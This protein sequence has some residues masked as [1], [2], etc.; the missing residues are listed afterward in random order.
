MKYL[1]P[2]PEYIK[3]AFKHTDLQAIF[4]DN[5]YWIFLV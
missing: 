2:L 5:K 4:E 3:H 1:P